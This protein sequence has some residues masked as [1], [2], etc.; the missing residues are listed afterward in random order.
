MDLC[1]LKSR[2]R[3][4][5]ALATLMMWPSMACTQEAE[6]DPFSVLSGSVTI[7]IAL[8]STA[9]YSGIE[10]IV[11]DGVQDGPDT[12]GFAT[13]D[14]DG[15][16]TM[17]IDARERGIFPLVL[18]R[19]GSLLNIS[20]I[21]V[22]PSDSATLDVELPLGQ[23]IPIIRSVENSAWQAFKNSDAQ[24][25]SS[26]S[27]LIA[28]GTASQQEIA[29]SVELASSILWSIRSSFPGTMAASLASTK[30]VVMLAGWN[31]SLL[32]DRFNQL[33]P[34]APGFSEIV[35]AAGR[36]ETRL[37]GVDSG[38]ALLYS[39][40]GLVDE[41]DWPLIQS[42]IG[43][44]YLDVHRSEEAV[45]VTDTLIRDYP[46]TEWADWAERARYEALNLLPGNTAP[47]FSAALMG[48]GN[49]SLEQQRGNYV[50]VEFW[51]PRDRQYAID[52]L[53]ISNVVKTGAGGHTVSWLSIGLEPDPELY[54]AFFEGR[55]VAGIQIRDTYEATQQLIRLYNVQTV[56]TRYLIDTQ[57]VIVDKYIGDTMLQLSV[58]IENMA[59]E[60]ARK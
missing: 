24:H 32:V 60:A 36:A 51:S 48:G 12:L 52:Q 30:S 6:P 17:N 47:P 14:V 4:L 21:V 16:F 35:R 56:P 19:R 46:D 41:S 8:D 18:K 37:H 43:Q 39:K 2:S 23:R 42:E 5:L 11:T 31:D 33:D 50:V 20:Q 15:R 58:D 40:R 13:T 57:G 49:V 38:I 10:V 9:D 59:A 3:Y 29:R 45:A 1:G 7:D 22:V 54:D 26:V 27:A 34:R 53:E 44:A 25:S 28:S 55:V